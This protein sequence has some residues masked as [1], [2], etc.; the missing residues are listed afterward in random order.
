MQ[1]GA[2]AR[3]RGQHVRLLSTVPAPKVT[4]ENAV[5]NCTISEIGTATRKATSSVLLWGGGGATAS[6]GAVGALDLIGFVHH[7][8]MLT[9]VLVPCSLMLLGGVS[10]CGDRLTSSPLA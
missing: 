10:K 4:A 6:A 9:A 8:E 3:Y 2:L 1:L 5:P 7:P